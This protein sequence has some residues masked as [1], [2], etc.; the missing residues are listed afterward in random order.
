MAALLGILSSFKRL[1]HGRGFGVHSPYAYAFITEVLRQPYAYYAYAELPDAQM[2]RLIFRVA[3]SLRPQRVALEG[4]PGLRVCVEKAY[5]G[6]AV[7]SPA[8]ADLI[9][10]DANAEPS[11]DLSPYPAAS[12]IVLNYR[13]SPAWDAYRKAMTAGMTFANRGTVAIGVALPHLPRQDFDVKF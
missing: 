12:A 1:R 7:V 2:Y 3:L 6:A 11:F 4:T 13:H 9:I 10:L 5:P 8:E